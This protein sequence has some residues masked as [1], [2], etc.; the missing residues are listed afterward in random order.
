MYICTLPLE[1]PSH[2]PPHPTSLGCHRA[3]GLSPLHH[4]ANSHQLSI[5]HMVMYVL[6]CYSLFVPPSP[7]PLCPQICSLCLQLYSLSANRFIG[8]IFLD[9]IYTHYTQYLF[10]SFCLTSLCTIGCRFIH[11]ISTDSNVFL[12]MAK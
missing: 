3:L 10:L 2:L 11:L 12:S 1:T 7:S 5:L 9:S 4:T 6:Q 8:T